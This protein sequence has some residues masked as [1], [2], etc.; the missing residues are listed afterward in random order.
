MYPFN[1]PNVSPHGSPFYHRN[2]IRKATDLLCHTQKKRVRTDR[3]PSERQSGS[4]ARLQLNTAL[5]SPEFITHCYAL[6]GTH[7]DASHTLRRP[8]STAGEATPLSPRV[9]EDI[10]STF[11]DRSTGSCI[12]LRLDLYMSHGNEIRVENDMHNV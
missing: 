11:N 12:C 6:R 4:V 10:T 2:T 8:V 7:T 1:I 3:G 5:W 9:C